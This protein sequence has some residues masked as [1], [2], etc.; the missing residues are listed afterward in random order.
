MLCDTKA[1]FWKCYLCRR[2]GNFMLLWFLLILQLGGCL[3]AL[4]FIMEHGINHTTPM[5]VIHLEV[6]VGCCNLCFFLVQGGEFVLVTMEM[7]YAW[8]HT[9]CVSHWLALTSEIAWDF[10]LKWISTLFKLSCVFIFEDIFEL[11]EEA[12]IICHLIS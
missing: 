9:W 11:T 8:L 10:V 1:Y 3:G 12:A 4:S 7:L 6:L 2:R 5:Y